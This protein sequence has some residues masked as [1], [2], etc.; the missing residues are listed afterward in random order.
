[1][2]NFVL[3]P[4]FTP[5]FF[6][7]NG[8]PLAGGLL[9]SY[10]AGTSIPAPTYTDSTGLTVNAN[11]IV[12]NSRG[13]CSLWIPINTF[14]KFTLADPSN[15]TIWTRDQTSALQLLSLYGGSDVGAANAY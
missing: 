5:Q 1:M 12:L 11:P 8:Q 15:N 4:V 7:P 2:T 3:P 9:Y 10:Q 14:L 6:Y 13:E